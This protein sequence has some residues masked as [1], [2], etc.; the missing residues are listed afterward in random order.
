VHGFKAVGVKNY[1]VRLNDRAT[2]KEF[3]VQTIRAID[4]QQDWY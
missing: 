3:S 1:K 4:K 2:L